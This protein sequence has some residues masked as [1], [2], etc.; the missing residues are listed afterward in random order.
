MNFETLLKNLPEKYT[1]ADID[2]VKKAYAFAEEAHRGITRASGEPYITH[3]VAVAGILA[4]MQMSSEVLAAGL[5]HDTVEDTS[6]SVET[7]EIEFGETIA[8]LVNAVTKLDHLPR[9]SRI[10]SEN[11]MREEIEDEDEVKTLHP[12]RN[13]REELAK[14]TLRKTFLAMSEDVRVVIIKLAD[15]L[16]NMR[17]LGYVPEEKR[18]RIATQTLEIFAPLASR[19]GIWQ[20]KWELEDLAFRYS[21]PKEYKKIAAYLDERRSEREAELTRIINDLETMLK[22]QHIEGKVTGRP[23]HLYSIFMKMQRKELPFEMIRDIRAVRIIVDDIPSCYTILGLIHTKWRPIPGE[24]DDYIAAPKDNFYQSLHTAVIY[25]DGKTLEVQIRTNEMHQKAEYGIA[26]HWRYKEGSQRDID[27]ER[28]VVWLRQMMEWMQDVEDASEFVDSMKSD[29]FSDRV[30]VFTPQGDVIDMPAGSTPIDFAYHVHTS[31]GDRCRGAKI[32][33]KLVPL[34]YQLKTGDQIEI[35][36]AKRGGPSRD[37]LNPNLGLLNSQRARAKVRRYFKKQDL[38]QNIAHGRALLEKEL[39]RLGLAETNL[40]I[41][42]RELDFKTTDNFFAAIGFGEIP[43]SKIINHLNL[44]QETVSEDQEILDAYAEKVIPDDSPK[45]SNISILGLKGLMSSMAKCCNP[46]PGDPIVGYITRGRG[47][48]IHRSDCPNVLRI[49]DRERLVSVSWG[50]AETTYPVNIEIK[51]YDRDG[52]V[53]DITTVIAEEGISL[54]TI[55]LDIARNQ[56]LFKMTIKVKN[57][58]ELSKLLNRIENLP[59]VMDAIR[60]KPG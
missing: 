11:S 22:T 58:S 30:Y 50:T 24:F 26:A 31:I 35:L 48:T 45:D 7:L 44:D 8:K 5:L 38:V 40:E 4:E 13:R 12:L 1:N 39:K 10:D 23:K 47:A 56:V 60:V 9:V 21:E 51:A 16:H 55:N 27:Y 49:R 17:T 54:S 57:I 41:L 53:K 14:E 29:V 37:W 34:S 42:A 15:R 25:S 52:L 43:I 3:C 59:N 18:K 2:L 46:A 36:T 33:G 28:R 32:N 6:V 20:V 19:L